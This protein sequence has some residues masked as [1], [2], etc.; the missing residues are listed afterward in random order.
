M[1]KTLA[2]L[3]VFLATAS[4]FAH[5]DD[6]TS[7]PTAS[8][9]SGPYVGFKV[10]A[11]VSSAA[12]EINKPSHTTVFPGFTAGYGFN[13]G[14]LMLGAEAFADLHHGSATYKDG[15]I[16]AKLGMP[17][18]QIM[19][20]ARLGFTVDWPATRPH[21]GLGVEYA[22]TKNLGVTAEWTSDH[23]NAENSSW[24]NNSFTLGMHYYFR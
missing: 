21:W 1:K 12:G 2:T 17:F 6:I 9:F 23:A 11:N 3:V 5:A 10:G 22:A 7:A 20:Y 24:H 13:V 19:P 16:D 8:L 15:G 14:P 4:G 18:G